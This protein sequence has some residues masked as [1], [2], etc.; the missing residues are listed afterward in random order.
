MFTRKNE[1]H[2]KVVVEKQVW[3]FKKKQWDLGV[4]YDSWV[5]VGQHPQWD[6]SSSLYALAYEIWMLVLRIEIEVTWIHFLC[7]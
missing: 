1:N 6:S 4:W 5:G 3:Y 7:F 2:G